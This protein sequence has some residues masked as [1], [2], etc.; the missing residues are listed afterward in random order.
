MTCNICNR[1]TCDLAWQESFKQ[2]QLLP[3]RSAWVLPLHGRRGAVWGEP[4]GHLW[5]CSGVV[6]GLPTKP[7]SFRTTCNI[8]FV[9]CH[10][11]EPAAML[12]ASLSR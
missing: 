4:Q 3:Q 11:L 12:R 5:D 8:C 7:D 9:Q 10:C 1:L 2:A 6:C